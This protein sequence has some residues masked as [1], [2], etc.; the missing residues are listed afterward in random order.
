MTFRKENKDERAQK[1]VPESGNTIEP[2]SDLSAYMQKDDSNSQT[3]NS[4]K[5]VE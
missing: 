5:G 1:D 4:I 2:S 3:K